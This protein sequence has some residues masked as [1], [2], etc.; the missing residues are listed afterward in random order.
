MMRY[1]FI[2]LSINTGI[3]EMTVAQLEEMSASNLET[4]R[5][6]EEQDTIIYP[7]TTYNPNT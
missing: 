5:I 6:E 2:D 1:Q 7:V 4:I 3:N